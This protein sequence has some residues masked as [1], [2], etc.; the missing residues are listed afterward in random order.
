MPKPPKTRKT[1]SDSLKGSQQIATFL[2][3]PLSVAQRWAKFGMP[4]TREGRCVYAS[5]KELNR[6]LGREDSCIVAKNMDRTEA[7]LNFGRHPSDLASDRYI[8]LNRQCL[9]PEARNLPADSGSRISVL[10]VVHSNI[11]PS[12][13]QSQCGSG[14]NSATPPSD[15]SNSIF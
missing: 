10:A 2:G 11:G 3:Q 5:P 4:V 6:W 12:P 1:E 15:K 8:G 13:S 14:T 7:R 9:L